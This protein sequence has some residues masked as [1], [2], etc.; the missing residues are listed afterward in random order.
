M[1]LKCYV[2]GKEYTDKMV[3]GNVISEE[4]NETLDSA[5][6]IL[7]HVPKIKD[8]RPYDDFFIYEG[9]FKGY[10]KSEEI[11]TNT[12]ENIDTKFE[13]YCHDKEDKQ[14][15]IKITSKHFSN[16]TFF[17]FNL[18]FID[19]D[20]D[21]FLTEQYELINE[22]S[23]EE[24]KF[25]LSPINENETLPKIEF[26]F[27][28]FKWLNGVDE[29]DEIIYGTWIQ[30][31]EIVNTSTGKDSFI[32]ELKFANCTIIIRDSDGIEGEPLFGSTQITHKNFGSNENSEEYNYPLKSFS[33]FRL[34]IQNHDKV[35]NSEIVFKLH[36]TNF[37]KESD[38]EFW[39]INDE[40]DVSVNYKY[41]YIND[42]MI[43]LTPENPIFPVIY[44]EK[45]NKDAAYFY[46]NFSPFYPDDFTFI[47]YFETF[48][49]KSVEKNI[50]FY[51]GEEITYSGFYKHFLV[52]QYVEEMINLNDD[53]DKIL[54]KYKIELFSETKRLE[55]IQIP[56]FSV[57]QPYNGKN[58]RSI[59]SYIVDAVDMYS[60]V[61]KVYVRNYEKDEDGGIWRYQK[62][63]T[64]D[65]SLKT[66]FENLYCPDF[67]LNNPNLRDVLSQ[68]MIVGDRIPY[69]VDDVIK[70]LDITER[71]GEFKMN[72][73]EITNIYSSRTSSN[74]C[75][76]LKRTYSNALS[77][78]NM[79]HTIEQVGFRNSSSAM[80]TVENLQLETKFPIYKINKIYMSYYKKILIR[81]KKVWSSGKEYKVG[82]VVRLNDEEIVPM[83]VCHTAHTS[84]DTFNDSNWTLKSTPDY[85]V[86]LCK[87]DITKLV[88][89]NSARNLI[90]QDWT[91]ITDSTQI[92]NVD[93]MSKY[94]FFTLGY[95]IGSNKITGFGT[96]YEYFNN[97]FWNEK[98]TYIQNILFN[99]DKLYPYGI[100]IDG[101]FDS[102]MSDNEQYEFDGYMTSPDAND[103]GEWLQK[104][105]VSPFDKSRLDI[106][107]TF[108]PLYLK[109][110]FFEIDYTAFYNGTIYHSKDTDRDDIV[111]NDNSSS[112]L[113][114]LEQDGIHQKEKANRFGNKTIQ[115]NARYYD[116]NQIQD[117]GSV[118]NYADEKD[119]IIYHKQYSIFDNLITC[120]YS[121]SHDYVL[122]NY[123]TSVYA[124]HR[125]YNL[126]SYGESV[127]RSENRKMY[128]MLSKDKAYIENENQKFKFSNFE[129]KSFIEN[130]ISFFK[131]SEYFK[132]N[133]QI[134]DNYKT[135]VSLIKFNN[136]YFIGDVN[137]FV[138]GNS[139]CFNLSMYDN[140]SAGLYLDKEHLEPDMSWDASLGISDEENAYLRGT[141]QRWTLLVDD[142][143]EGHTREL[144]IFVGHLDGNKNKL[145]DDE[146]KTKQ[147]IKNSLF[148]YPK[149]YENHSNI[150]NLIGENYI[151]N[152]DNKEL[153][154]MTFQL[155]IIKENNDE[156]MFFSSW[157]AKLSDMC[158]VYNKFEKN[159]TTDDILSL[160]KFN[161]IFA[162]SGLV[163]KCTVFP[164]NIKYEKYYAPVVIISV[165]EDSLL[166]S[167]DSLKNFKYEANDVNLNFNSTKYGA[168]RKYVLTLKDVDSVDDD[169]IIVNAVED[170]SLAVKQSVGG[171][172]QIINSTNEIK[173]RFKKIDSFGNNKPKEG[174]VWYSN[175]EVVNREDATYY[176]TN[177]DIKFVFGQTI[178]IG[179]DELTVPYSVEEIQCQSK[180]V[181]SNILSFNKQDCIYSIINEV[182]SSNIVYNENLFVT[183]SKKSI[184]KNIIYKQI[185][186]E[187]RE[188]FISSDFNVDTSRNPS[189][190]LSI[191]K[192]TQNGTTML[193]TFIPRKYYDDGEKSVQIWYLENN[194]YHFVWGVNI[195]QDDFVENNDG[196]GNAYINYYISVLS[197]RDLRVFDGTHKEIG[198]VKN[199]ANSDE[200][201]TEQTYERIEE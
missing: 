179:T 150:K 84:G 4:Y 48:S 124:K 26:S 47:D 186:K 132:D 69:V 54:Y 83:Y 39:L 146:T 143:N 122:K 75:D 89:L 68:L 112:S 23:G 82:D 191:Q 134:K 184:D 154:D 49:F 81:A 78:D 66:Y 67:T 189:Y 59:Y 73:G 25:F 187:T 43:K 188:N 80:L 133:G 8:L 106:F 149:L 42:I 136:N 46:I 103:Y 131:S 164:P 21:V 92:E 24:T 64:V 117:L 101:Y 148:A 98:A 129:D 76:I 147:Y 178:N 100:N 194:V 144:G 30:E 125:P 33:Q 163:K 190:I 28:P 176:D 55:T 15:D 61:Y 200:I 195:E 109:S 126:M 97:P 121:G 116:I 63:Y 152:K 51:D 40:F 185:L 118:F 95:D 135:N 161:E 137:S 175:C 22:K 10:G 198:K 113:T 29:S 36:Q 165:W 18:D 27:V 111:I 181:F 130:L 173:L 114:L 50:L 41:E 32:G 86:F 45:E 19:Y 105:I 79:A 158:G 159:I 2:K 3:Q 38:D 65:E 20:G 13:I 177:Y 96:M 182:T 193:R 62:K 108:S 34:G 142:V 56:N 74:H 14:I 169:E 153:I 151:L 35:K 44:G 9:E 52:D 60:P 16:Y 110:L 145:F 196:W 1:D 174:Q 140:V 94:K 172:E 104:Y 141:M 183:T 192:N 53:P 139:L 160:K 87:Q 99:M 168:I 171:K 156:K 85:K 199:I 17:N 91:D 138:S 70:S 90:S 127:R 37:E 11:V 166:S 201:E 119:V 57:T 12:L 6:V 102:L 167:G 197:S 115:I 123:F 72:V 93:D 77:Q 31:E 7:S 128:V 71:K 88:Q 162:F 58:K 157:M 180:V 120:T 5:S 107:G 170:V 155:E